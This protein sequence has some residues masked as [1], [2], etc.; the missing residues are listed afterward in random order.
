MENESEMIRQQ[1]DET[2]TAMTEKI[3]ML[4]HQV[5]ETVQVAS[6][7]VAD[8]V[9]NVKEIVRDSLQTVKESVHE[10]VE[11]VKDA[12]DLHRQVDQRPWTMFAGATALGY[13]GACLLR[14]STGREGRR[15]EITQ[16]MAPALQEHTTVTRNG[17]P[18]RHDA[19]ESAARHESDTFSTAGKPRLARPAGRHVPCGNLAVKSAGGGNAARHRSR[20]RHESGARKHGAPTGRNRQQHHCQARWSASRRPHH[21]GA[22]EDDRNGQE[23]A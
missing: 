5:V 12:F 1:M 20:H 15:G 22:V 23:R 3:E 6:T 13:L 18:E 21:T 10:T 4:E 7:A 9:E 16:S 17:A 19:E 11:T 2:R 8:T 14:G